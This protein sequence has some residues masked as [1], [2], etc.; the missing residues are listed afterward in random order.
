MAFGKVN[1]YIQKHGI[2]YAGPGAGLYFTW[3]EP[4][5]RT[6]FAIGMQVTGVADVDDPEL[7]IISVPESK[8]STMTVHGDYEQLMDAHMKMMAYTSEK[9]IDAHLAIEEYAVTG[10]QNPDPKAWETNLYYLHA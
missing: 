10:M 5:G 7:T 9:G 3:D 1:E 4:K 6:D 2:Q 8:A